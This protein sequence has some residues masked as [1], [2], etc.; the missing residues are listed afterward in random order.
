MTVGGDTEATVVGESVVDH[1]K[2]K[3]FVLSR[4]REKEDEVSGASSSSRSKRV[5]REEESL[6]GGEN[7]VSQSA[8]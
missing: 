8:E 1:S 2:Q 4:H 3:W 6:D 5:K 7:D